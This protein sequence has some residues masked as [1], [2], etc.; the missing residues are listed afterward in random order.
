MAWSA[1]VA[2]CPA[3]VT[4]WSRLAYCRIVACCTGTV[5]ALIESPARRIVLQQLVIVFGG[6]LRSVIRLQGPDLDRFSRFA[7]PTSLRGQQQT[8][9]LDIK[10]TQIQSLF[11]RFLQRWI[12]ILT[13]QQ[14]RLDHGSG[15]ILLAAALLQ[16]LPKTIE[17]RRPA[18]LC[19]PLL[20]RGRTRESPGLLGQ[21]L[22]VVLQVQDLLLPVETAFV[23]GHTLPLVPD[24]HVRRVHFGLHFQ[25]HRNGNRIEVGQHSHTS[26]PVHLRKMYRR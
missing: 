20:Q 5:A 12:A 25:A 10:T 1:T 14:Q 21:R 3:I 8:Q 6:G 26:A 4:S 9:G 7:L 23:S 2:N 19:P 22:Q 24:L 16:R 11:Q 15:S 18:P 17:A 13:A